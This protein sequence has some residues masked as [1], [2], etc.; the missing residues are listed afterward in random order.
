[1]HRVLPLDQFDP[2]RQPANPCLLVRHQSQQLLPGK[3]LT[4]PVAHAN[5]YRQARGKPISGF[6]SRERL[7]LF[8][9]VNIYAQTN[10][11]HCRTNLLLEGR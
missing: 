3:T 6:P 4:C 1:M 10:T 2:L 11:E 7:R 5:Y 8:E 9:Q